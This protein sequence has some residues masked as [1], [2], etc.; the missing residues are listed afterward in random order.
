MK[1]QKIPPAPAG[2]V[3][4]SCFAELSAARRT[5]PKMLCDESSSYNGCHSLSSFTSWCEPVI[6]RQ[7]WKA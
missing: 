6:T 3:I 5:H 2:R 4:K 1:G 7:W